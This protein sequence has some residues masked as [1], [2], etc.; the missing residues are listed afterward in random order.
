MNGAAND[1]LRFSEEGDRGDDGA[2]GADE[3]EADDAVILG[4]RALF[5][6]GEVGGVGVFGC[7]EGDPVDG[8][9]TFTDEATDVEVTTVRRCFDRASDEDDDEKPEPSAVNFG[10]ASPVLM[11]SVPASFSAEDATSELD[12]RT[13]KR[14]TDD[15]LV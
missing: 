11:S 15:P 4:G 2:E 12:A 6:T 1:S 10:R 7:C 5:A 9:R 14:D 3:L 8:T 13:P